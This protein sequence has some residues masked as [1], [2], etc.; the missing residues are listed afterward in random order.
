MEIPYHPR[1]PE[2]PEKATGKG[3]ERV[4][5]GA[6]DFL[7]ATVAL[8]DGGEA[9]L[10][11]LNGMA[12]TERLN[13]YI[14]RPLTILHLG[15]HPARAIQ[16]G[17]VWTMVSQEPEDLE[18]ACTALTEGSCAIEV[19]RT[20][21]LVPVPTE[22]KRSITAP[23]DEPSQKG[24]KDSFV[25]ALRT[26]TSLVRRHLHTWRLR[27]RSFT[28]G[29]ESKTKVELLWIEGITDPALVSRAAE[30]VEKLDVDALLGT[31]MLT[32]SLTAGQRTLFPLVIT[33][34]RPDKFCRGLLDGRVG[35]ICDGIAQGWLA[36]GT[37][38]PYFRAPQD[39]N[40]QWMVIRFLLAVRYL[41]VAVS[42]LLPAGYISM[43]AF[44]FGLMPAGMAETVSAAR[45]NVPLSPPL[46]VV[47]LLLAF[48]ILQEAG[49]RLPQLNGQSV[50]IIGSL[51][52][53]QAAVEAKLLSPVVV[54]VI[55]AAGVAGYTLPD[56]DL[57]NALR[58][59]RLS[60]AVLA[61]LFGIVGVIL[62]LA[63]LGCHLAELT[64][65]GVPWLAPFAP[66]VPK[67]ACDA[68][69]VPVKRAKFR[70]LFLRPRDQRS[71]K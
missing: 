24:A 56:Q 30:G 31:Q 32:D 16:N 10:Y 15:K 36:P 49:L 68:T 12:R 7:S 47:V 51:V 64:P 59:V 53:G 34:Q 3:L 63:W 45:Q 18:A 17:G 11:W 41:C 50:S 40:N 55:A 71:Q 20:L 8:A 65:L 57:A 4:F 22:E 35:V 48:E 14:I 26:N 66:D 2:L 21:L 19:G 33:T 13:D 37:V 28:V 38:G 29:R 25:E 44:H 43:A 58:L 61:S 9:V 60:L 46:E 5:A 1:G 6:E 69:R 67:S 62:G 70:E 27:I 42:L 52:V 23:E 54:V 39:R